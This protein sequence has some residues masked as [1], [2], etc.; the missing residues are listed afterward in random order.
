[1]LQVPSAD[2][3]STQR[4]LEELIVRKNKEVKEEKVNRPICLNRSIQKRFP[5][6]VQARSGGKRKER[7]FPKV[8]FT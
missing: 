5:L 6:E 7:G 4:R 3:Q 2:T 1:M 8:E